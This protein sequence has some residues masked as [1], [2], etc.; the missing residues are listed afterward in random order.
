VGKIAGDAA[1]FQ[2]LRHGDLAA[3]RFPDFHNQKQQR[4]RFG[5]TAAIS[6]VL[7][8]PERN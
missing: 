2:L 6:F 7:P 1:G 3:L 4:V 8:S 5:A